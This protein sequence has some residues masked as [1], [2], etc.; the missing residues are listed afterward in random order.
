MDFGERLRILRQEK[1]FTLRE[2]ANELGISY[3][4]L[5]KY[6]RN[7]R[8][9][10]F[11]TLER[12]ANFFG[13]RIDWL[14]GRTDIKT[15]DEYIYYN[16]VHHLGDK[17]KSAPPEIRKI[18][19]NIIDKVFL[20]LYHQLRKE[21]IDY[22]KILEGIFNHLWLISISCKDKST[23]LDTNINNFS[24]IDDYL[25]SKNEINR[26]LDLLIKNYIQD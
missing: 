12:I 26:L 1:S 5:G 7:E 3:S 9:P 25:T 22:L 13:V 15:F 18:A 20:M 11:D 6:E 10:D 2:L 17:I 21:N 24:Y 16:D 14:L 23:P 4:T 8:Q 19:S